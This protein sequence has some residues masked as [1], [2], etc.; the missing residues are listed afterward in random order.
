VYLRDALREEGLRQWNALLD[1][2]E[3][4]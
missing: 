4:L 1:A 3:S 2:V